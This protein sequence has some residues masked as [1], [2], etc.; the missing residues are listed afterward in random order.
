MQPIIDNIIQK[1]RNIKIIYRPIGVMNPYSKVLA[2]LALAAKNQ[3]K[4]VLFHDALMASSSVLTTQQ[5]IHLAELLGLSSYQL[6][7]DSNSDEIMRCLENNLDLAKT[8]DPEGKIRLPLILLG[9]KAKPTH[10]FKFVGE[11]SEKLL[12]ISINSLSN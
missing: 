4:F 5:I 12:Q 8:H 1:N 2:K 6:F 11:V 9:S 3:N 10:S 7:H